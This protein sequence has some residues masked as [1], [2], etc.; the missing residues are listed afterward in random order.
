MCL[1]AELCST[2]CDPMYVQSMHQYKLKIYLPNSFQQ[3]SQII[4][5]T[6]LMNPVNTFRNKH[7]ITDKLFTIQRQKEIES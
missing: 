6:F 5:L 1:M 4:T 7:T 2:L 3:R